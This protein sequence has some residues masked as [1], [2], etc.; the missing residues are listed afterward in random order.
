MRVRQKHQQKPLVS[1]E[2]RERRR[3][4][5][6]NSRL[7]RELAPELIKPH[8][9]RDLTR[10]ITPEVYAELVAVFRKHGGPCDALFKE[11]GWLP[12]RAQRVYMNGYPSKG[13]K[14]IVDI[15]AEDEV[16]I[17]ANRRRLQEGLEPAPPLPT[18][19]ELEA[20]SNRA[21]V[22]ADVESRRLNELVRREQERT[23]AREDAIQARSEEALLL[24]MQRRNAIALNGVTAQLM[25]GAVALA[26]LIQ[27]ELETAA[28]GKTEL[29]LDQKLKLVRSAASVARFNSEAS[30]LAIKSERLVL[31]Q[32]VESA[33][34]TPDDGSL[35][36]A[37]E[38]IERSVRAVQRARARGLLGSG[39]GTPDAAA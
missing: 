36:Q 24:G 15:I 7:K 20:D 34:D 12:A 1:P 11:L 14:P 25:K 6:R 26:G 9:K 39:K 31:G 28:S 27:T 2:E 10:H 22:I 37:V 18:V 35:E 13:Y 16:A 38:W 8:K 29:S 17:H 32:P 4:S 19:D 23:K 33:A 30:M 3:L 21:I 5:V